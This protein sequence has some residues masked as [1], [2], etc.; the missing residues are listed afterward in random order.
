MKK[1]RKP[2]VI[3]NWKMNLN[4]SQAS[5]LVSRLDKHVKA[6]RD[7]EVVLAPSLLVLQPVSMQIDRHKFRLAAQNAYHKDEGAFTG[8][9]SFTMLR[10]L[11]GYV[12][13]G[14]SERRIYFNEDLN[15]IRDKVSAC[16]RNGITPVL[17][18]GES[19]TERRAGETRQVLHDQLVTAIS[20][21]TAEEVAGMVVAYEPVWA[22]STF[23]GEIAKPDVV[24]K[25][26]KFIRK[27]IEDL[28]GEKTAKDVRVIYG[29]SVDDHTAKAY[30]DI[31][32]CDG[33]L[34]GGASLNY[35]KFAG[36]VEAAYKSSKE[37]D[38]KK[39]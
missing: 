17:C 35:H 29:G 27:Q 25:D 12:L 4:V 9:V 19:R 21:L 16:V 13:I 18:I 7:V 32:G 14:H 11:V 10:D 6:H 5:L 31:D 1:T 28:Y 20:D 24:E 23:G 36:I 30:L 15:E 22:I 38:G 8:E 34:P 39:N 3:G 37:K 33:V 26:L 2:L